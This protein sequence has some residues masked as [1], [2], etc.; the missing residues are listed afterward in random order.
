MFKADNANLILQA[1]CGTSLIALVFYCVWNVSNGTI[2]ADSAV[3]GSTFT[4]L[5][6]FVN[7]CFPNSVGT[8]KKD[9]T[10]NTLVNNAIPP[11]VK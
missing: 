10:I 7:Y 8:Q 2:K 4:L 9:D 6:V 11:E 5:V 3:V 1:I